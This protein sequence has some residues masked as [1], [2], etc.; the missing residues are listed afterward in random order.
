MTTDYKALIHDIIKQAKSKGADEADVFLEIERESQ[1]TSRM[2]EIETLKEAISRGLGIRVLKDKRLGFVYS[3]DFNEEHL[4][5]L[6]DNAMELSSYATSDEFNGLPE[7]AES[8]NDENLDLYDPQ[9]ENIE[10]PLKIDICKSMEKTMFDYDN[11]I[12]NSEGASFYDGNSE[13]FIANSRGLFKQAKSSYCYLMAMPVASENGRLQTNYWFSVSRHYDDLGTPEDVAKKAAGRTVRM[14]NAETAKTAQVPVVFDQITGAAFLSNILMAVN[15]DAVYK[16]STFLVDKLNG[17]I[18]SENV[19][20]RDDAL[21]PRAAASS[22]FDGEGLPAYN[23]AIIENGKLLSYMYDTYTARK[24]STKSTG[25][26]QRGFS[27][28]PEIGGFNF[29]LQKGEHTP[30]EIISTIENGLYVT[31]IMGFGSD[32]TTGDYSQ[33]AS[34][35]WI[36]NGKL[37]KPVEG[38]TIASNVL[39]MLKNIVMIGND[40]EFMGPVSSPTFKISEMIVAGN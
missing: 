16:K 8:A 35:I 38:I 6:V 37:T 13:I 15:G 18:G 7:I 22:P 5:K 26:A 29:Y 2:G 33:G 14:L 31:G 11:R 20:I 9:I 12:T 4:N 1:V 34:G 30:G 19:T 40:L 36:E 17:Q 32:I 21:I 27:S 28:T 24:A 3:S 10:Q 39:D 25:N 23:K